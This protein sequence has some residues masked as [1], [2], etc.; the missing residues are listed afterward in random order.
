MDHGADIHTHNTHTSFSLFS[1]LISLCSLLSFLVSLFLFLFSFS[2]F[3]FLFSLFSFLVSLLFRS[4]QHTHTHT[5]THTHIVQIH[6]H[7]QRE[8]ERKREK[9][10]VVPCI[11]SRLWCD[12]PPLFGVDGSLHHTVAL[13]AT[14]PSRAKKE[15]RRNKINSSLFTRKFTRTTELTKVTS[16]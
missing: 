16:H 8:R 4:L 7:T 11:F 1:F 2:L 5:H 12:E 6:S 13:L 15:G 14:K 3:L 10:G 9:R